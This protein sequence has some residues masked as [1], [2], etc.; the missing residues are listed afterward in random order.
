MLVCFVEKLSPVFNS[1][2]LRNGLQA[3]CRKHRSQ[4]SF[5]SL[6]HLGCIVPGPG[7]HLERDLWRIENLLSLLGPPLGPPTRTCSRF[8]GFGP[9]GHVLKLSAIFNWALVQPVVAKKCV[10]VRFVDNPSLLC[11]LARRRPRNRLLQAPCRECSCPSLL[12]YDNLGCFVLGPGLLSERHC[13]MPGPTSARC[14]HLH[15]LSQ[16][17]GPP[18]RTCSRFGG[19]GPN[20]HV[21]KQSTVL[22]W[23]LV[24]PVVRGKMRACVLCREVVTRLQLS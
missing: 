8:G 11:N 12:S 5:L 16:S 13:V 15:S 2:R 9:N 6:S 22:H 4:P 14:E 20:S 3:R 23:A 18:T 7:L 10:L 21:L 17:L 19:F 24:Q 1:R